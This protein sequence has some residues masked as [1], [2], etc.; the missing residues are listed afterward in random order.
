MFRP[1]HFNFTL[2]A[3][4]NILAAAAL[5]QTQPAV[6]SSLAITLRSPNSRVQFGCAPSAESRIYYRVNLDGKKVAASRDERGNLTLLSPVCT[7]LKCIVHWND[8]D[9]TWDCPCHGS[10]FKATGEVMGAS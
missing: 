8:A 2:I 9:R 4:T 5:A 3:L 1:S 7:H 6:D 10:R